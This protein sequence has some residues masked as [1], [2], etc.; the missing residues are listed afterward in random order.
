MTHPKQ[1]N[2]MSI[3]E[4]V[5]RWK[6]GGF[7]TETLQQIDP[8][9]ARLLSE[10][11]KPASATSVQPVA[12]FDDPRVQIVYDCDALTSVP[13]APQPPAPA[14]QVPEPYVPI[15]DDEARDLMDRC[16]FS[17][18]VTVDDVHYLVFRAAER[19][20]LERL[21]RAGK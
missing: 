20:V 2:E 16:D 8:L 12:Q 17:A 5:E 10:L 6:S 19:A 14:A 11:S 7:A 15:P 3:T 9:S 13:S 18:M 1:L 21:G 4:L